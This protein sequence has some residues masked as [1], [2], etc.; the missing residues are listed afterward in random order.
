MKSTQNYIGYVYLTTNLVNGKQYVGQHLATEFDTKY[1]GS[2]LLFLKALNKYGWDN[3]KCEI[4]C[5]CNT[6]EELNYRE[7]CEIAFH[8][9][10]SPNGY[11]LK[12]GGSRGRL[13]KES[14]F[15]IGET[16][17]QH[18]VKEKHPFYGK[19]HTEE[20]K[21]KIS[22]ANIGK[23]HTEENRKKLGELLKKVGE[24]TRWKSGHSTW[25]KGK[26]GVQVAWNKGKTGIYSEESL[27][28][29]SESKKGK[30]HTEESRKKMSEAH[31]GKLKSEEHKRKISESNKGKHEKFVCPLL[32]CYKYYKENKSINKCSKELDICR[33]TF[34]NKLEKYNLSR[35]CK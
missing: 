8:C 25:N 26:T 14:R 13:R 33:A 17:K 16:F 34:D 22:E 23:H 28:K 5:W 35:K 6:Q 9:C 18:Y 1:K 24:A 19:H 12:Y 10:F 32:L 15:K 7:Q 29:M 30:H 20:T 3:F 2:G 31:K 4:I 11:N 27:K 21:K